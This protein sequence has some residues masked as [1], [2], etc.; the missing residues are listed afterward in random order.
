PTPAPGP[1]AGGDRGADSGDDAA[2]P[3]RDPAGGNFNAS[4]MTDPN[5]YLAGNFEK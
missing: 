4:D 2:S 3:T 1:A 5:T